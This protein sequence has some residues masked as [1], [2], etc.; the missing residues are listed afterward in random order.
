[1]KKIG[2]LTFHCAHNYGAVLQT[3]ATQRLLEDTGHEVEVIDYRP[4][5]LT[6]P[7][8]RVRLSRLKGKNGGLS[9]RHLV[10]EVLLFPYR[11]IRYHAFRRFIN[12]RLSLSER[13]TRE[14]F[15]G[16]YD[17]IVV[18]SDQV[19]NPEMTGGVLDRMYLADFAFEKGKRRYVADAVSLSLQ[20]GTL[21]VLKEGVRNFDVLSVRE[22]DKVEVLERLSGAKVTHIQDPV[23][24]VNPEV[25][26]EIAEKSGRKRPYIL[27]Y[28][29][30]NHDSIDVFINELARRKNA[31]I[32]EVLSSPNGRKLLVAKQA[33]S[34]E[35][36]LGLISGAEYVVT[37]SFHGTAFSL[38]FN[39][40]FYCFEF[41]DAK[42]ARL[43]SLLE[44][45]GM[46]DRMLSLGENVPENIEMMDP[47]L[48]D[49]LA[50][51]RKESGN[52]ILDAVNE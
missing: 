32:V 26:H 14:S 18:G 15:E 24:Q 22:A 5:S 30:R 21:E 2:I 43:K 49:R 41:G 28:R 37:T 35:K 12:Y 25:W 39:R 10:S 4:E 48:A 42:D 19:W 44:S 8:K 3:Y 27:V 1:M 29:L 9:I 36:F 33:V 13:V 31:E 46:D 40:P 20:D 23:L 16:N 17:V 52:F 11:C 50:L 45:V 38:V 7:Y 51:I 6:A 34:V 47:G